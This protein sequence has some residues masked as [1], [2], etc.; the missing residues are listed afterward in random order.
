LV[1]FASLLARA[2]AFAQY[3][4]VWD[5]S[6]YSGPDAYGTIWEDAR[7]GYW[8]MLGG[9]QTSGDIDLGTYQIPGG[10]VPAYTDCNC[11]Q[12]PGGP[13]AGSGSLE[14]D[15]YWLHNATEEDPNTY[16]VVDLDLEMYSAGVDNSDCDPCPNCD[17][18]TDYTPYWGYY[19]DVYFEVDIGN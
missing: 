5:E 6:G 9:T 12:Q 15:D 16:W 10:V 18:A 17:G 7:F 3:L 4:D 13:V 1:A 19:G 8:S 11:A 2:P 14:I